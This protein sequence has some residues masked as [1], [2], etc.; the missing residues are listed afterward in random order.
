MT[1]LP[2]QPRP[3]SVILTMLV[4]FSVTVNAADPPRNLIDPTKA[5]LKRGETLS[6]QYCSTCH[7]WPDPRIFPKEVWGDNVLPWMM[8]YLGLRPATGANNTFGS[9]AKLIEEKGLFPKEPLIPEKDWQEIVSYYLLTAPE[10]PQLIPP[11]PRAEGTPPFRVGFR[12]PQ[13]PGPFSSMARIVERDRCI[14][15]GD[16]GVERIVVLDQSGSTIR[17][18]AKGSSP[19]NVQPDRTNWLITDIGSYLPT[20]YATGRILKISPA[21]GR[22]EVVL[23]KLQRPV[24]AIPA[25]FNGD[26]RMDLVVSQFGWVGG[27]FS[28]FERKPDGDYQEHVLLEKPGSSHIDVRDLNGDGHTDIAVLV[29]QALESILFYLNDGKGNFEM[30]IAYQQHP[31]FGLSWFEFLDYDGDGIRDLLTVNGDVDN[32]GPPRAYH[33]IRIHRGARNNTFS[34]VVKLSLPGA[35]KAH[36]RDFDGDGDL[37]L[38]A[39]AFNPQFNSHPDLG[40]AYFENRGGQTFVTHRLPVGGDTRWLTMDSG[41]IDGDGDDDVILGGCWLGPGMQDSIPR[42]L[43]KQ[44]A[45]YPLSVCFLENTSRTSAK[46]VAHRRPFTHRWRR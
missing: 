11:V 26:G 43:Q 38:F 29:A 39:I 36:A 8:M 18:F 15:I 31:A 44:W 7:L 41:D 46:R 17:T 21:G 28:W 30:H 5:D 3:W 6:R 45:R 22:S 13:Y 12:I 4:A 27:R 1:C 16:T 14:Q 34:E 9:S 25:D 24:S 19:V 23:E 35:Y 32:G 10:R 20:E 37:D 40:V 42:N 33:G 2:V